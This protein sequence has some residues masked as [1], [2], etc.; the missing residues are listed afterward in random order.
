M[1]ALWV[2]MWGINRG[3]SDTQ[4]AALNVPSTSAPALLEALEEQR[5]MLTELIAPASSQQAEPPRRN[6]Q[7]TAIDSQRI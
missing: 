4:S 7:A 2:V 6:P 5:R 3:L 1:A